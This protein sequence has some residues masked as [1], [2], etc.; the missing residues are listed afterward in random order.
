MFDLDEKV[1]V[2]TGAA[3]ALG[4]SLVEYLAAAGLTVVAADLRAR[5]VEL[6]ADKLR[7]EGRDVHPYG[8]D[9]VDADEVSNMAQW[10]QAQCGRIDVLINNAA[11]GV[12]KAQN[13]LSLDSA[14]WRRTWET[15]VTGALQ[16]S[17]A[18]AAAMATTGGGSIINIASQMGIVARPGRTAY[19]VS[20]AALIMLTKTLAIDLSQMSIRVNCVAPGPILTKETEGQLTGPDHQFYRDKSLVGRLG[21]PV[22]ICGAVHYLAS[23]ASEYV[24]GS[25]V[26]VDGGY[27]TT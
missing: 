9:I 1:C 8:I 27:L 19:C 14:T 25:V 16:C 13:A 15:N 21:R 12:G 23:E 26:V 24:T 10:V 18:S 2:V 22:D 17:Q 3:G 7:S 6:L 20:K 11:V 5:E 4:S